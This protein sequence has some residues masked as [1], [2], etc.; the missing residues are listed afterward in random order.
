MIY[1][2]NWH[3]YNTKVRLV[4]IL[5][6]FIYR[7]VFG[8]ACWNSRQRCITVYI[9]IIIIDVPDFQLPHL[10]I[11]N[12]YISFSVNIMV[13]LRSSFIFVFIENLFSLSGHFI[14]CWLLVGIINE[15]LSSP[16]EIFINVL[17]PKSLIRRKKR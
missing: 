13:K 12:F 9:I 15:N 3:W 4:S 14:P 10:L 7:Y 1:C 17:N 11:F 5:T 8:F 2:E 16:Y 6:M